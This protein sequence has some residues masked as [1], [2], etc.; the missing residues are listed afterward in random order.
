MFFQGGKL[1]DCMHFQIGPFWINFSH[2][3]LD[4]DLSRTKAK[5]N[6]M[7]LPGNSQAFFDHI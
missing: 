6:Q 5:E 3:L 7:A 1:Q 2:H 4:V